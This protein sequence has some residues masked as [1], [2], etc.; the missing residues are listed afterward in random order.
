MSGLDGVF[1]CLGN[2]LLDIS[3]KVDSAF[4][5]KY[6]LKPAN[7]I[8]A[9]D[10]HVPMYAELAAREDV[11]Y[12]AGGAG[13]NTTRVLQ[14]LLQYPQ[15]TTYMGCIGNDDF[16]RK[17]IETATKDGVNVRY[18]IDE[19][20]PTGVCGVCVVDKDRSLVAYLAAAN[21][22]KS[23]HVDSNWECV[24]KA[25]VVYCTGFFITV[26]PASIMS[27]AKHC[28]AND[29]I[30]CM[31]LSAPFIMQVPPFKA[32]LMEAMPYIDFLFGNE[33]E[34]TTFAETEGW[35]ERDLKQVALKISRLPKANGCRPRVVVFTQGAEPT[36]VAVGGKV[37]LFPVIRIAQEDLVDTNGAGDAF[38]GGFLSQI[39][40]GK[41]I[42]EA[43]RA[44][45]YAANV[46]IQRPGCTFPAKPTF[47]WV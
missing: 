14:W 43:V 17:M 41:D 7:Q 30:Y 20:T 18:Q 47:T 38:V 40:L 32:V 23:E 39:V 16:G 12:I 2:P 31:N 36:I 10:K 21:N 35:E 11:E 9:E 27:V 4:L 6:D 34:A 19:S 26:S 44:G 25:R 8:L 5:E 46:I 33:V 29:K 13:Q 28:A 42:P 37:H 3:S 22:F 15:A 1:L 45:N 24:D